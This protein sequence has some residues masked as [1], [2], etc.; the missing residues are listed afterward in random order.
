[1]SKTGFPPPPPKKKGHFCFCL[2]CVGERQ[3]ENVKKKK[4]MDKEIFKK[5][6]RKLVFLGG[7]EQKVCVCV[8]FAQERHF[9][10]Q[11]ANTICVW[12]AKSVFSLTLSVFG[13]WYFFCDHIKSPNTTKIGVSAGTGENPKW[14]VWFQKCYFGKGPRKGASLSV[15][16]KSFALLKTLCL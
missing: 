3:R 7:R 5:I 2:F 4:N 6:P 1:M 11:L 14:Y 8:C 9:L 10:E 15:I 16:H 13:K 12:K